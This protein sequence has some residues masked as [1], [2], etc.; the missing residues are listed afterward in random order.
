MDIEK[1]REAAAIRSKGVVIRIL[2]RAGKLLQL[3]L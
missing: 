1:S 2:L 3:L